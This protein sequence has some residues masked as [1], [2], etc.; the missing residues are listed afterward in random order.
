MYNN[1]LCVGLLIDKIKKRMKEVFSNIK[2]GL[3]IA[4]C[5]ISGPPGSGKTHFKALVLNHPRPKQRSSTP[6]LT[7]AKE[8]T[9]ADFINVG[10]QRTGNFK[11]TVL[12]KDKWANLLANTI[13]NWNFPNDGNEETEM[14][15]KGEPHFEEKYTDLGFCVYNLLVKM[16]RNKA[17]KRR[18]NT[19]NN[20]HL[21]YVV[22]TGGQPQFQEILPNFVR[23]SINFLVHKL[24]EGLDQ[25]PQFEYV[26]NRRRYTIPDPLRVTNLSIIEQSVRSVCSST[27]SELYD[28]SMV[29]VVGTFK[30]QFQ[31]QARENQQSPEALLKSKGEAVETRLRSYIEQKGRKCSVMSYSR[32]STIFPIDA[33]IDGWESNSEVMAML[34]NEI[35]EYTK[36][37]KAHSVPISYFV[38]LQNLKLYSKKHKKPYIFMNDLNIIGQENFISLSKDDIKEA[39]HFFNDVN[40][41]LYFPNSSML[42]DV[43]F[44][45]PGFLYDRVTEIIVSSFPQS[46]SV[47]SRSTSDFY[48][49]GVFTDYHLRSIPSLDF[50]GHPK[51]TKEMFLSLL[52][53]LFIIAELGPDRYFMP[54]V[55]P[56]EDLS[57][58]TPDCSRQLTDVKLYMDYNEVQGPL[59]IS[60]GDKVT[61]RGLFCAMV[62]KLSKNF[63]WRLNEDQNAI[64]RRNMIEF[65]VYENSPSV[66]IGDAPPIGTALICDRVSNIELYTTCEKQY[67]SDIRNAVILSLYKAG[68]S[69]KYNFKTI[70]VHIGFYCDPC[71][72]TDDQHHA[73]VSRK[74]GSNVW[75]QRCSYNTRKRAV[76]L[77]EKQVVWFEDPSIG[78][79]KKKISPFLLFQYS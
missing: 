76:R 4:K 14:L 8:V 10:E 19:M 32:D 73:T 13:Y 56:M 26:I 48:N 78:E 64:R 68:E 71:D 54:C 28:G 63:G 41:I 6:L 51:F 17:T 38:F 27:R 52:Q 35:N 72:D 49:S 23:S 15:L 50:S 39:L 2:V 59:V 75:V 58:L 40:L 47:T 5:G 22:D 46:D 45:E 66:I 53:D 25:F 62:T 79:L 7:K 55:L 36:K 70:G 9:T 18:R 42:S 65:S 20:I 43:V 33:S 1:I 16:Y 61:P 34:K 69:L 21:L 77:E 31:Q 57:S 11:W 74:K 3:H 60:F 44:M 67:C 30:D 37:V 24:S 29:A 12:K